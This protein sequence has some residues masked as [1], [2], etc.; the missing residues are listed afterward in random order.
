MAF[1]HPIEYDQASP[2]V[3]AVYDDIMATRKADSVEETNTRVLRGYID[4]CNSGDLDELLAVLDADVVHYFLPSNLR[5]ITGVQH[6][7]KWFR[8][9][10][11]SL[12]PV[13]SIDRLVAQGD[14]VV[15]EWSCI[16]TPP[17]TELRLMQRG[18]EWYVLRDARIVEIRSYFIYDAESS[19]ELPS[20]PYASRGYLQLPGRPSGA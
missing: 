14:E 20:F 1:Q 18:S 16:W 8:K 11:Q 10:K 3:R 9:F 12:N 19:T 17:S 4:G 2:V 7:A 15:I 13:W 6:L 5:P